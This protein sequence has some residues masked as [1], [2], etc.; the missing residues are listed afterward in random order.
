MSIRDTA[1]A[2]MMIVLILIAGCGTA[3]PT[4]VSDANVNTPDPSTATPILPT[5]IPTATA[6][7]LPGGTQLPLGF[8]PV[9][10]NDDWTPYIVELDGV[11]MALVPAG[12]FEMGSTDEQV[13]DAMQQCEELCG[14]GNCKRS[15]Y[16]AEQPAERQ[17]FNEPFW[18]DVYEVTNGQ[19]GSSGAWSGEEFPRE[20][21][22]WAAA[23]AHCESRG[24][25]AFVRA[26]EG[27]W[28]I[29]SPCIYIGGIE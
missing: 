2:A 27:N 11:E 20:R 12:C 24:A 6:M 17:C 25:L 29:H 7:P 14:A 13:D 5:A 1:I 22:N 23:V 8:E 10:R 28:I 3:E 26:R 18:I 15:W 21:V 19:Y 9:T 4:V 16:Q